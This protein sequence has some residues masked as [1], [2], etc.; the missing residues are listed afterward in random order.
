M[1]SLYSTFFCLLYILEGVYF[2]L[3][4]FSSLY[5]ISLTAFVNNMAFVAFERSLQALC[6]FMSLSSSALVLDRARGTIFAPAGFAGGGWLEDGRG[7]WRRQR[8]AASIILHYLYRYSQPTFFP[9]TCDLVVMERIGFFFFD[10]FLQ[11][12]GS[13][14]GVCNA[15]PTKCRVRAHGH[16]QIT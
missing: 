6:F 2:C 7:G 12:K 1:I 5:Y 10:G 14:V 15:D 4:C 11:A 8:L 16:R 3:L 9:C 13:A